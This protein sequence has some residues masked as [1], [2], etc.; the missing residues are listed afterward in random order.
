MPKQAVPAPPRHLRAA[1]RRWFAEVVGA[2]ALEPH[3]V[4]VLVRACEALDR[5]E[6]AREALRQHGLTFNDKNG[7]P[8]PRPEIKI[9]NDSVIRFAR[10]LRE[11]SLDIDPPA[12]ARPPRLAGTG[13]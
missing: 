7:L 13:N 10:L 3:H 12:E 8:H 9:E 11:L 5:A 4:K 6:Q 2:Y 1:T